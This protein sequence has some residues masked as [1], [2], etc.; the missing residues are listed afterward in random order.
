MDT[1]APS[2]Q[3][4]QIDDLSGVRA[5]QH[6]GTSFSSAAPANGVSSSNGIG[7]GVADGTYGNCDHKRTALH[8]LV[9]GHKYTILWKVLIFRGHSLKKDRTMTKLSFAIALI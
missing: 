8:G 2:R 1:S 5:Q 4:L 9:S 6:T 3:R 7:N